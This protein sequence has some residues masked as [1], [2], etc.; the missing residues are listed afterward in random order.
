MDEIKQL[1]I[2]NEEQKTA[3]FAGIFDGE[4]SVGVYASSNGRNTL[5]GETTYWAV[6][7]SVCGNWKNIY[8]AS[9]IGICE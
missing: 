2:M 3:Y 6:R 1:Y 5:S 9:K 7:L 8:H 4:G